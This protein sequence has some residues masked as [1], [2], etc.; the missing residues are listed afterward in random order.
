MSFCGATAQVAAAICFM[1][2]PAHLAAA[3]CFL[4]A[5]AHVAAAFCFVG[6]TAC[7]AAAFSG[8]AL[9]VVD[10]GNMTAWPLVGLGLLSK[11]TTDGE[12]CACGLVV[13]SSLAI[14]RMAAG[15][16]SSQSCA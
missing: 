12:A 11:Y 8:T 6:A 7:V 5:T 10:V 15:R 2:A 16:A 1:G 14:A 3:F 9:N 13:S 4:G